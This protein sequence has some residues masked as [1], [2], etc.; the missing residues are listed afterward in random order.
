MTVNPATGVDIYRTSV[1]R[2][3]YV[4]PEATGDPDPMV[5][6]AAVASGPRVGT[7]LPRLL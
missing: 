3:I 7:R 6:A 1:T 5:V 4:A 2:D